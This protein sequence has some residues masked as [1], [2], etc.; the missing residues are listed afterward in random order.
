MSQDQ[1]E[2][3]SWYFTTCMGIIFIWFGILKLFPNL[4]PAECLAESTISILT[5]GWISGRNACLFLAAIEVALGLGLLFRFKLKLMTLLVIFHMVG[6]MTPIVLLPSEF[7]G[8]EAMSLTLTGQ[9][10]VKNIVFIGVAYFLL[11][12]EKAKMVA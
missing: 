2:K 3:F 4:S 12:W 10:I 6:T 1:I 5:F 8:N 9:Y 7:F 11:S